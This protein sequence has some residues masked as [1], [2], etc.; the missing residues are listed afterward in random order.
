[1]RVAREV[2]RLFLQSWESYWKLADSN[3]WTFRT[4]ILFERIRCLNG[5]EY[6][7]LIVFFFFTSIWIILILLSPFSGLSGS[8][9]SLY[10]SGEVSLFL[11]SFSWW[12]NG[13]IQT[14]RVLLPN[15]EIRHG[16]RRDR[17]WAGKIHPWINGKLFTVHNRNKGGGGNG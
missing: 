13:A 14:Y 9:F 4:L 8:L 5:R 6:M 11:S 17:L 12:L 10:E 3:F 1:M 15:S 2:E 16:S 7:G